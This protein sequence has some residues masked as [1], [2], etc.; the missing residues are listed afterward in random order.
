[1]QR[2]SEGDFHRHALVWRDSRGWLFSQWVADLV[3]D[4]ILKEQES[5]PEIYN[6]C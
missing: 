4:I 6:P 2:G 1:M 5:L 3:C